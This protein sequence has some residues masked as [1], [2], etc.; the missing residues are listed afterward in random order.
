MINQTPRFLFTPSFFLD[1]VHVIILKGSGRVFCSGWDLKEF[2]EKQRPVLGSQTMP[3]GP[4][5]SRHPL[6]S[7]LIVLPLDPILDFR[8]MN[9]ATQC[10][11]SVWRSLKPVIARV[12]VRLTYP[13]ARS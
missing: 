4:L 11:M 10:F 12:Q 9:H 8:Y 13:S 6:I 5:L 2:A 7:S 1:N 3:W